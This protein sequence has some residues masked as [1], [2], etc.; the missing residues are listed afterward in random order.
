MCEDQFALL[1]A[2]SE[3]GDVALSG[4]RFERPRHGARFAARSATARASK[5]Q[6]EVSVR[7]DAHAAG[8]A[9]RQCASIRDEQPPGTGRCVFVRIRFQLVAEDRRRLVFDAKRCAVVAGGLDISGGCAA[10]KS[11]DE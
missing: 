11:D 6:G 3:D 9:A 10:A 4:K 8:N 7:T 5:R 2:G 1:L